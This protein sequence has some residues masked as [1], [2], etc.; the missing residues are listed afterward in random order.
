MK[1]KINV[2]C[3]GKYRKKNTIENLERAISATANEPA[4]L[5]CNFFTLGRVTLQEIV[6]VL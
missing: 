2:H 3:N 6:P 5:S 4:C 1:N